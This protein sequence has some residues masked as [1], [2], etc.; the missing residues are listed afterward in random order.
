MTTDLLAER[1]FL[2]RSLRDLDAER[3][4]GDIDEGDY[5]SLK[6]DYTARAAAVLKALKAPPK[7][8]LVA[9]NHERRGSVQRV[10]R[11]VVAGGV[12]IALAALSGWAVA[13]SSGD[14]VSGQNITGQTPG[15][16][17]ASSSASIEAE[18]AKARDLF[19]QQKVLEAIKTYDSVLAKDPKQ[20][21]ALAYR[22]WL[23]HLAG[24][25]DRALESLNS[26]I[27]ADPTFPDTHFFR[28]E[29]LC[30]YAHDQ[31]GAVAEFNQFL[32]TNP[33]AQFATLVQ[34][35]AQAAQSGACAK[36]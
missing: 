33:P 20:P 26:A 29:L 35:R 3:A 11:W 28:G 4:A 6:A 7:G 14:R 16:T 1:D 15:D 8:E 21:E 24:V 36:P 31:Q 5:Q 27:A 30:T 10:R 2:L 25:D 12:V 9:E 32:A 34:Q 18:L 13:S 23:L 19:G 22:G 17:V